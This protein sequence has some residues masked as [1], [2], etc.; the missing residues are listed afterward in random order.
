MSVHLAHPVVYYKGE[1][2]VQTNGHT[3]YTEKSVEK[4]LKKKK[5]R[6]SWKVEEAWLRSWE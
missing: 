1:E 2:E 6:K 5:Q 3:L 4:K